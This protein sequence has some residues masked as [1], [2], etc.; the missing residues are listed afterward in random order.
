MRNVLGQG[1]ARDLHGRLRHATRFVRDGDLS[2]KTVLDVGCGF[3]WFALHALGRGAEQYTGIEMSAASLQTPIKH[4]S[5][6]NAAF[7]VGNALDIP[8]ADASF[9]TVVCWEV[10]EHI[11]PDTE[12]RMLHEI[13]RVLRAGGVFYFSTP[14]RSVRAMACD[15]AFILFGHRHYDRAQLAHLARDADFEVDAMQVAG[16]WW[17]MAAVWNLYLSKWVLRRGLLL[18]HFFNS[19]ADRE[20]DRGSGWAS[21]F[22]RLVTGGTVH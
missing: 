13:R 3:G 4:V 19:K 17:E 5:A 21:L 15:P 20:F 11:P 8:F 7:A 14:Y 18:E 10:I 16:G 9:D 6:P 1:P 22:G 12:P 2:G